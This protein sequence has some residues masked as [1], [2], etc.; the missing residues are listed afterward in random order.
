MTSNSAQDFLFDDFSVWRHF[1]SFFHNSNIDWK[2]VINVTE[3]VT[4]T[5]PS[6]NGLYIVILSKIL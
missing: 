4:K 1:L 2:R 6:F 3:F 5:E